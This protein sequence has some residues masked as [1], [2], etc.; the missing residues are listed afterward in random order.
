MLIQRRLIPNW[1]EILHL[2]KY[3]FDS[4]QKWH[5]NAVNFYFLRICKY[6]HTHTPTQTQTYANTEHVIVSKCICFDEVFGLPAF[7]ES[8]FFVCWD[9]E[10]IIL[11]RN[12]FTENFMLELVV[13]RF[14][15]TEFYLKVTIYFEK[16][17]SDLHSSLFYYI[18]NNW[19]N[20]SL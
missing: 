12:I 2:T 3:S 20:E 17:F 9:F 6:K 10:W 5:E 18:F 13:W 11:S 16:C 8:L 7:D 19:I 14:Q 1:I 4:S 15:S